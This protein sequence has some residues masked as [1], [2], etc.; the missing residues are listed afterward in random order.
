MLLREKTAASVT[1]ALSQCYN[2]SI[3]SRQ[4]LQC[5]SFEVSVC[6]KTFGDCRG[7]LV[8]TR[9][10]MSRQA[11]DRV[12]FSRLQEPVKRAYSQLCGNAVQDYRFVLHH[13]PDL[14]T[15]SVLE[16]SPVPP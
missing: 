5:E 3:E 12:L 15:I 11:P 9:M 14:L 2:K 6:A 7:L 8:F 1:L 16:E 10:R 4:I 13:R